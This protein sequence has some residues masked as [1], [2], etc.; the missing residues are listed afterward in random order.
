MKVEYEKNINNYIDGFG[1][2]EEEK[3]NAIKMADMKNFDRIWAEYPHA[4]LEASEE[5]VGLNKGQAGNSE[6]GHMTIG[7]GKVLKQSEIIS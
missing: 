3:G 1:I 4:L 2:R 7:A 6:V 5:A